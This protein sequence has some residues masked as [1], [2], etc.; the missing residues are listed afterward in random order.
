MYQAIQDVNAI[1]YSIK[2]VSLV[3]VTQTGEEQFLFIQFLFI[4]HA[5][6]KMD[7]CGKVVFVCDELG[8]IQSSYDS[9]VLEIKN[10]IEQQKLTNYAFVDID[11][12]GK[13]VS[14][15]FAIENAKISNR[16]Y[17]ILWFVNDDATSLLLAKGCVIIIS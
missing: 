5:D 9:I 7:E 1:P 10:C 6:G 16:N 17:F 14:V 13:L 2:S 4:E 8:L 15:T 3:P 11:D 12:T